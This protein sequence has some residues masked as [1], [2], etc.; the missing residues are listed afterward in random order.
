MQHQMDRKALCALQRLMNESSE[1]DMEHILEVNADIIKTTHEKG[2]ITLAL[3]FAIKQSNDELIA[4]LFDRLTMKRDWFALMLYRQDKEFA[5]Q[6]FEQHIDSDLLDSKDLQWIIDNGMTYLIRYLD[7]KKIFGAGGAGAALLDNKSVLRVY[8]LRDREYY[9]N[10]LIRHNPATTKYFK[11]F[12]STCASKSYD[13]IIDGGSVLYSNKGIADPTYLQTMI[14]IMR[15]RGFTPLVVIHTS[16]T[17]LKLKTYAER[18]NKIMNSEMKYITPNGLN[19]DLFILMAYIVKSSCKIVTRDTYTDHIN[20]FK[21]TVRNESTDF[22]NCLTHD[23]IPFT[24]VHGVLQISSTKTY[25]ECIQ[26][27]DD[28]AY[29]PLENGDFQQIQIL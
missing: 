6:M 10:K 17:N 16:H 9:I 5:I 18:V 11:H 3:R 14:D 13:I 8:P 29:L 19:D 28:C 23:L 22:G 7:G 25:S 24:N 26:V 12:I 27:T 1:E 15:A 2:I 20:T 21:K 4:A